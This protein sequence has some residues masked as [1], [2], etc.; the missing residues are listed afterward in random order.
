MNKVLFIDKDGVINIDRKRKFNKNNIFIFDN[1]IKAFKS[2]IK[3]KIKVFVIT[4]Q[5]QIGS[6][7]MTENQFHETIE[8]IKKKL[9][10]NNKIIFEVHFCPHHETKGIKKY[11]KK[12]LFRKPG[13]LMLEKIINKNKFNRKQI[14]MIGDKITD[15][16]AAKK[17]KIKFYYCTNNN[18]NYLI[19]KIFR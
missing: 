7:N 6:G 16:F 19:S 17:S 8:I 12:C 9:R 10:V 4:N 1:T 14:V 2:L 18:L 5:S 3:K 15:F 13:N 11:K